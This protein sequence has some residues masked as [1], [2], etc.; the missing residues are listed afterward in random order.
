MAGQNRLTG[1]ALP[2]GSRYAIVHCH[3]LTGNAINARKSLNTSL[4]VRHCGR[5]ELLNLAGD[6]SQP[7]GTRKAELVE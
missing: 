6:S 4:F 1:R 2:D 7:A 5:R 3:S